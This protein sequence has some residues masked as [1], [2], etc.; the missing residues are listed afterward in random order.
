MY[1]PLFE[2]FFLPGTGNRAGIETWS[3]RKNK[4]TVLFRRNEIFSTFFYLGVLV[5]TRQS[6]VADKYEHV[7]RQVYLG[8]YLIETL[9]NRLKGQSHETNPTKL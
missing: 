9:I 8:S 7:T 2:A 5:F 1:Q 3:K 4:V 6:E